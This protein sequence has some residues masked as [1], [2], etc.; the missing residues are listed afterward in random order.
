MRSRD[1]VGK[2]V[3]SIDQRRIQLASHP[4]VV[5][6]DVIRFTDG[7][8]IELRGADWGD[9]QLV[10]AHYVPWKL[11]SARLDTKGTS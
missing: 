1:I 5:T 2:T 10:S 4:H 3:A 9:E 8:A 7:S 11:A 6:L